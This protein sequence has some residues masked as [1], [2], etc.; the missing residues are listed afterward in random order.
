MHIVWKDYTKFTCNSKELL[1]RDDSIRNKNLNNDHLIKKNDKIDVD[2]YFM[3][4]TLTY[5]HLLEL[6]DSKGKGWT[7]VHLYVWINKTKQH[8]HS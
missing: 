2:Y 5:N 4:A 3:M 7:F 1:Y 8:S 6:I